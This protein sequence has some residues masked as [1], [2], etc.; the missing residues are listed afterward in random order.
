M[1]DITNQNTVNVRMYEQKLPTVGQHVVVKIV[2][3]DEISTKVVL[4]EYEDREALML[5]SNASIGRFQHAKSRSTI[6]HIEVAIVLTIDERRGFIDVS[7]KHV[8][9]SSID[10]CFKTYHKSKAA[11]AIFNIV[12]LKTQTNLLH[13]YESIGWPLAKLYNHI[14]DGFLAIR[15]NMCD[16]S[17]LTMEPNIKTVLI[18]TIHVKLSLQQ[19][20]YRSQIAVNCS[21]I[22]GID[23]IRDALLVGKQCDARVKIQYIG[24]LGA[25]DMRTSYRVEITHTNDNEA[26]GILNQVQN[27]IE[28]NILSV[29]GHFE[30]LRE[31]KC[32][33]EDEEENLKE[34]ILTALK[35]VTQ[36]A[37]DDD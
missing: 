8:D 3:V 5:Q 33:S 24:G 23:A 11:R 29:G 28:K 31:P 32:V 17:K 4:P 16:L 12:S 27:A 15:D 1:N 18:E 9:K 34:Q 30:V 21:T 20:K 26:I 36:V 6:G 37:A 7:K 19:Q 2:S 35:E 10:E 22:D 25:Q 13:L 14:L